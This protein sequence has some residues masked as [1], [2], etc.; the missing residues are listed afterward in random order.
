MKGPDFIT[1]DGRRIPLTWRRL[2]PSSEVTAVVP[3]PGEASLSSLTLAGEWKRVRDVEAGEGF[4]RRRFRVRAWQRTKSPLKLFVRD[5]VGSSREVNP[6][7]SWA[8]WLSSRDAAG[9]PPV[10]YI[11]LPLDRP[12]Q[13]KELPEIEA[14]AAAILAD[15]HFP[16]GLDDPLLPL[17]RQIGEDMAWAI[18]PGDEQGHLD[19]EAVTHRMID[20]G[21]VLID[22]G[23]LAHLWPSGSPFRWAQTVHRLAQPSRLVSAELMA[24]AGP[25]RSA[26]AIETIASAAF[27]LGAA[28]AEDTFRRLYDADLRASGWA[29]RFVTAWKTWRPGPTPRPPTPPRNTVQARELRDLLSAGRFRPRERRRPAQL[30]CGGARTPARRPPRW[31]GMGCP[32]PSPQRSQARQLQG[33]PPERQVGRLRHHRSRG[34]PG[35]PGG[36]RRRPA[37]A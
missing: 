36:I 30:R 24:M 33:Q 35:E 9:E 18:W 26:G 6:T 19:G 8:P 15:H 20:G 29:A 12:W 7:P 27:E 25:G 1:T 37:S 17:W 3:H 28:L 31:R 2:K 5:D 13:A 32:K 21:W 11:S 16:V 4:D 34:R 22:H 23:P 10:K 14:T